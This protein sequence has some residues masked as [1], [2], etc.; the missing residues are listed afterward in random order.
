[1]YYA[2]LQFAFRTDARVLSID[3]YLKA[4]ILI[5]QHLICFR[6][7]QES[8]T[9]FTAALPEREHTFVIFV[10]VLFGFLDKTLLFQFTL[11]NL[12]VV[13][14]DFN[15][16]RSESTY[17]IFLLFTIKRSGFSQICGKLDIRI[18]FLRTNLIV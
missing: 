7:V 10:A 2:V 8:H 14:I 5:F 3:E 4:T 12:F 15:E 13:K 11:P 6:L 16:L 17:S 1:M 18:D 9:F